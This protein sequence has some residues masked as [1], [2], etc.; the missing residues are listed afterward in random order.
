MLDDIPI[1]SVR[2]RVLLLRAMTALEPLGNR[3]LILLAEH[4]RPRRFR[5][6][7]VML[8]EGRPVKAVHFVV[9]GVVKATVHDKLLSNVK[10]GY[11]VGFISL[12]ARYEHGVHAVAATPVHTLEI[13]AEVML[14]A[15]EESFALVR[16]TL[17][18]E[19]GQ[20]VR[21]RGDL[22]ASLKSPPVVELGSY[23]ERDLTLVER[24][25]EYRK[26]PLFATASLDAI[27]ELARSNVEL[28]CEPGTV[29]WQLDAPSLFSLRIDYG[30]VRCTNRNGEHV[31]IGSG[32]V[33]GPLDC[34]AAQLRSYSARCETPVVADRTNAETFLAVL[35][36]HFEVA[37]D[38]IAILA[39]NHL[40]GA[41]SA[42]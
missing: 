29:L 18:L 7:E 28:R 9:E 5:T 3:E 40:E 33:L 1:T 19:A 12:L 35:E 17:R 8:A 13:P 11:G 37:M 4:A 14:N 31:D 36:A 2:D 38:L 30:R 22:P 39:R 6:G 42:A 23:R 15:Y 16:N 41:L 26:N 20:L 24:I 21:R 32:Y 34:F 25:I 27:G 10:R